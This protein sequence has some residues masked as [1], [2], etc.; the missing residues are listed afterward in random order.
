MNAQQIEALTIEQDE[1]MVAM[2]NM[3][4]NAHMYSSGT[5][6]FRQLQRMENRYQEIQS[7]LDKEG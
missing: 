6:L 7:T 4:K 5:S 1:I 3:K 2:H